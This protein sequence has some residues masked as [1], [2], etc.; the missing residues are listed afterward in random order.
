MNPIILIL[1]LLRAPVRRGSKNRRDNQLVRT[2]P[3]S[4]W[5]NCRWCSKKL[6]SR[7][8]LSYSSSEESSQ[9]W[10]AFTNASKSVAVSLELKWKRITNYTSLDVRCTQ[11]TMPLK[12]APDKLHVIWSWEGVGCS[13]MNQNVIEDNIV[14]PIISAK[15]HER[16]ILFC[17]NLHS[18]SDKLSSSVSATKKEAR[19][20]LSLYWPTLGCLS[21]CINKEPKKCPT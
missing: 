19:S 17:D 18:E 2:A 8:L 13:P 11:K 9:V 16:N 6:T 15:V 20:F 1:T 7:W 21:L 12:F 3:G 14:K 10:G 4:E 5:D